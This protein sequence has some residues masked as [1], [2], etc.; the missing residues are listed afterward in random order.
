[1]EEEADMIVTTWKSE[2][3]LNPRDGDAQRYVRW[4]AHHGYV[5]CEKQQRSRFDFAQG[6]ASADD[7]PEAVR[8]EADAQ[9]GRAF[10]YVK[11]PRC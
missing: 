4:D 9:R 5:W 11:W 6:T 8:K 1:M 7:V 2:R 3:L 10:S